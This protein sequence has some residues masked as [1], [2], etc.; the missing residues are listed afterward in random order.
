[1]ST[2]TE[3]VDPSAVR[4]TR[5]Q[6]YARRIEALC[7]T[8]PGARIALRKGLRREL[9]DAAATRGM[10]RLISPW[11]PQGPDTPDGEQR[12]YYTIAAL[13]A[14]QPRYSFAQADEP[15]APAEAVAPQADGAAPAPAAAGAPPYRSRAT[16]GS[17]GVAF[18]RAVVQSPGRDRE[19]RHAT[20]ESR[21]NLLTRQSPDGLHR[22]LPAT[23]RYLRDL[24]V[25]VDWAR[26]LTDLIDWPAR[27]GRISRRWLQDFYWLCAQ[28]DRDRASAADRQ[29]AETADLQQ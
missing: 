6:A 27:S 7:R 13:I 9:D 17:L 11:L 18:A 24:D 14:S 12:A 5:H 28:A 8:D 23:V 20:A 3:N 4:L 10:H 19:M 15:D 21:L 29:E 26:L 16:G 1:M 25:P 22:H 2:S